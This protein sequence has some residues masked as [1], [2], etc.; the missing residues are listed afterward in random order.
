[1]DEKD[2][3]FL[4]CL[5]F[6][7]CYYA[8]QPR[9]MH[10][11][12]SQQYICVYNFNCYLLDRQVFQHLFKILCCIHV[13]VIVIEGNYNHIHHLIRIWGFWVCVCIRKYR[14]FNYSEQLFIFLV[15]DVHQYFKSTFSYSLM[16]SFHLCK[17]ILVKNKLS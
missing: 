1:M 11:N 14:I 17:C 13:V 8:P 16:A 10:G 9:R 15:F 7:K 6:N 2:Y 3:V 4:Q 12:T 5:F